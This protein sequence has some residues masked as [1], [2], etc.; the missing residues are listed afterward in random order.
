MTGAEDVNLTFAQFPQRY[1]NNVRMWLS[2]LSLSAMPV[3][4][5]AIFPSRSMSRIMGIE[6]RLYCFTSAS[7]PMTWTC[8]HFWPRELRL[9]I[10]LMENLS[11]GAIAPEVHE[12]VQDC[13]A[14]AIRCG[15]FDRG[16]RAIV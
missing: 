4:D 2:K 14:T 15:C 7:L 16:S 12:R 9:K 8:P 1:I 13:R 5:T 6:V 10:H 11:H 3:C